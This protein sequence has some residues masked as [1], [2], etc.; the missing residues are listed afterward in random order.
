MYDHLYGHVMDNA[1]SF[2]GTSVVL[3][4]SEKNGKGDH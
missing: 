3:A 4:P 2:T 1:L